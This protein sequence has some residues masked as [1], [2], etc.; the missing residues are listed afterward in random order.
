M[1]I[2]RLAY[3]IYLIIVPTAGEGEKLRL[4]LR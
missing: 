2:N 1:I 4:Q 3:R